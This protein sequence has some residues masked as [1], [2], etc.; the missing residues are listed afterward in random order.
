[1]ENNAN[2]T[3][4]SA[5]T[6]TLNERQ[7]PMHRA[8]LPI[9]TLILALSPMLSIV[10]QYG[11]SFLFSEGSPT[12]DA[13]AKSI[14]AL[15][16]MAVYLILLVQCGT[17]GAFKKMLPLTLIAGGL[18]L[19][20]S[21][22]IPAFAP[23]DPNDFTV[24]DNF[25]AE[26]HSL[27]YGCRLAGYI[28]YG[29]SFCIMFL[30]TR[31]GFRLPLLFGFLA[32]TFAVF[33]SGYALGIDPLAELE[34]A[35]QIALSQQ[36]IWQTVFTTLFWVSLFAGAVYSGKG[37]T[38]GKTALVSSRL[39]HETPVRIV[40][41]V[42]LVVI[43]VFVG[44]LM[45]LKDGNDITSGSY[46][47]NKLI[48]LALLFLCNWTT[49]LLINTK[50][51]RFSLRVFGY[52]V[53]ALPILIVAALGLF[54]PDYLTS[55]AERWVDVVSLF[56]LVLSLFQG[57]YFWR[58]RRTTSDDDRALHT[59][60][61]TAGLLPLFLLMAYVSVDLS[62]RALCLHLDAIL[63]PALMLMSAAYFVFFLRLA[64]PAL[65]MKWVLAALALI[66][67]GLTV[68]DMVATRNVMTEEEMMEETMG[69]S[70]EDME[71]L[72]ETSEEDY[73][74][75][76]EFSDGDSEFSDG[77]SEFTDGDSEFTDGQ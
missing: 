55:G 39:Y 73:A 59:A 45:F 10:L 47:F 20:T 23:F 15:Y 53:W 4:A 74:G 46:T 40:A 21:Q 9:L 26:K 75:D 57:F 33:T 64:L 11:L 32:A 30:A 3:A 61:A 12:A 43:L 76:E 8:S 6:E 44:S 71:E 70:A 63:F 37:L 25:I 49:Q 13:L 16:G 27:I 24:T 48:P 54:L 29:I 38:R 60:G 22:L 51:E 68:G 41:G 50:V 36:P 5:A 42:A 69:T 7:C 77:D 18:C 28:L 34:E 1:M 65:F 52:A 31:R 17:T 19:A 35:K 14:T 72:D 67:A 58:L 62:A 66:M 56:I 2:L